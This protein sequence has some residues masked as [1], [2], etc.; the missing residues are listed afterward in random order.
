MARTFSTVGD[1]ALHT[2]LESADLLVVMVYLPLYMQDVQ[3]SSPTFSGVLLLPFLEAWM[4]RHFP[5]E[6]VASRL[7][8]LDRAYR[9]ESPSLPWPDWCARGLVRSAG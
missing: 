3:Y 2:L 8:E 6:K 1:P 5:V 9:E 7:R 4:G